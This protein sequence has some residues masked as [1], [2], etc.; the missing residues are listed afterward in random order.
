MSGV[1]KVA[2]PRKP[3]RGEG[4]LG[5]HNKGIDQDRPR[6]A[7]STDVGSG[8]ACSCAIALTLPLKFRVGKEPIRHCVSG[9]V[10]RAAVPDETDASPRRLAHHQTNQV[11]STA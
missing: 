10:P 8:T 2:N 7:N 1:V 5:T 11:Q 9:G 3:I 4:E 6:Q